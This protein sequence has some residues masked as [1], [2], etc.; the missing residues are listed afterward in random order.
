MKKVN[1][2]VS[3]THNKYF[4]AKIKREEINN[5]FCYRGHSQQYG[6]SGALRHS[7]GVGGTMRVIL[8]GAG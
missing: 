5:E 4:R 1:T 2:F 3:I 6:V 7:C 8:H